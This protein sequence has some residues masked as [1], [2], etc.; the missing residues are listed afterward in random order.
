VSEVRSAILR[1]SAF[2]YTL[3]DR[4]RRRSRRFVARLRA[5]LAIGKLK[6]QPRLEF[7]F[8]LL[9][10][11][12]RL[13]TSIARHASMVLNPARR[14]EITSAIRAV[15]TGSVDATVSVANR[16][17]SG[18]IQLFGRGY[19]L[20]QNVEW[21]KDPQ[22]G[23]VWPLTS[24]VSIRLGGGEGRDC[25]VRLLWELNRLHHVVVLGKAFWYT[26]EPTYA[27]TV[28]AYVKSWSRSNP[29]GLG[30]NWACA[31]EVAIRAVN[32]LW[33]FCLIR[34]WPGL[35]EAGHSFFASLLQVHGAYVYANLENVTRV[36]G[37]HYICDLVGL[38]CLGFAFP[39]L[40]GA[41]KWQRF[42]IAELRREIEKQVLDD[43]FGFEGSTSYH[44]MV[45]EMVLHGVAM[46][47]KAEMS[48]T[49]SMEGL[50]AAAVNIFG[51]S[52]VRRLELMCEVVASYTEPGGM[53]PQVGDNDSGRL[54]RLGHPLCNSND[55][56]HVLALGG[57]LLERSD[58]SALGFDAQE[59][60][61][62]V[63]GRCPSPGNG[64][65]AQVGSRCFARSGFYVLRSDPHYMIVHCAPLGTGGKGTHSHNDALSFELCCWG[66]PFIVDPGTYAYSRDPVLRNVLR[67]TQSHN[68]L[69]IDGLEQ[70][71][72]PVDLFALLPSSSCIVKRWETGLEEDVFVGEVHQRD[73]QDRI[74]V[75]RRTV[76]F[77]K[78]EVLWQFTDEVDAPG[79]HTVEWAFHLGPGVTPM[80]EGGEV[81]L[82]TAGG[83]RLLLS[84]VAAHA[85]TAH[86]TE[87]YYSPRYNELHRSVVLRLSAVIDGQTGAACGFTARP[88]PGIGILPA[89]A[90][91]VRG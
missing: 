77:A 54:V 58:L 48:S 80:V 78:R 25:D 22:S 12:A 32:L 89:G 60:A 1:V 23:Y 3:G 14:D 7:R 43:G 35:D 90:A 59:D 50:R 10:G 51:R 82:S 61:I 2:R 46:A 63:L 19:E 72:L 65:T 20:G 64:S 86:L 15:D 9:R 84:F 17:C 66:I 75:L 81:E 62:W 36:R 79:R 69:A 33:A 52:F 55:H 29:V 37:N 56:R 21:H 26:R 11:R 38:L 42:A 41:R 4:L 68:T 8:T 16:V 27:R 87:G 31:M 74:S 71:D 85:A 44:C 13:E 91:L 57:A 18:E 39:F 70:N 73:R 83:R 47:V 76:R 5:M 6:P 49:M 88:S 28:L 24:S 34:T 53:A 45:T 67:S 40:R 30:A